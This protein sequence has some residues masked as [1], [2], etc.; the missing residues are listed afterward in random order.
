MGG[1]ISIKN[2]HQ[3]YN[4]PVSRKQIFYGYFICSPADAL[5][6]EQAAGCRPFESLI[7]RILTLPL[8]LGLPLI[9]L[10]ILPKP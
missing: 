6:T 3:K 2:N 5:K 9:Y 7:K 1:G 8:I 10:L 4:F